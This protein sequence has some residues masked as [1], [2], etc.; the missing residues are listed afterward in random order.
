MALLFRGVQN[1]RLGFFNY[2]L[3]GIIYFCIVRVKSLQK[4]YQFRRVPQA[5]LYK[6][7]TTIVA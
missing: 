1:E 7:F 5:Y 4:Y 2:H 3:L 6:F